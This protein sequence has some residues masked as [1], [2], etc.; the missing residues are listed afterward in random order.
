MTA[1]PLLPPL[2]G[3]QRLRA[4]AG[5]ARVVARTLFIYR[6]NFIVSALGLLVQ[7]FLLRLVWTAV[8]PASEQAVSGGHVI[9]LST[10][11]TYSTL[12]TVQF[13]LFSPW[14]VSLVPQRVRD[15]TIAIDLTRPVSFNGQMLAGQLGYT[16]GNA[17]F[18]LFAL[19]FAVLVGGMQPPALAEAGFG[20]VA[21]LA[22]GYLVAVLLGA[23]MGMVAFWTLELKGIMLVYGMVS[24]FLSGALV[25]LWF[26]PGW[27]RGIAQWLP[28]QGMDYTP[29]AIYLGQSGGTSGVLAA[30][31]VQAAW[32]L[33]LSVLLWAVS[34]RALW[35]VTV[36]GG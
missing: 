26:M 18:A 7:V 32:V 3:R 27:L 6:S 31:G 10:Q 2:S 30:V 35:R 22:L 29:I 34:M 15:G 13:S 1:A 19:P 14:Q 4:Y 24:Q 16:L 5:I 9:T 23:L 11:I 36:Q 25:P 12:A 17:P 33:V 20:Y 28:F 8:F 21:S